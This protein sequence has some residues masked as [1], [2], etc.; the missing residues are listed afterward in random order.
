M[1]SNYQGVRVVEL[2]NL[3]VQTLQGMDAAVSYDVT[4]LAKSLWLIA[5]RR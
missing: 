3:D 5:I 4:K 2:K 1:Q